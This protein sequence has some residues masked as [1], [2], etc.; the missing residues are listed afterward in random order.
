MVTGPTFL[1]GKRQYTIFRNRVTCFLL[2][3]RTALLEYVTFNHG[4]ASENSC[5]HGKTL[6]SLLGDDEENHAKLHSWQPVSDSKNRSWCFK[7][8]N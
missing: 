8:R 5:Y 3:T 6:C 7:S 4:M 2:V 1:N